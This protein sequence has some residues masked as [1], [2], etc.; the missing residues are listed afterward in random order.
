MRETASLNRGCM[1]LELRID[2]Q[3]LRERTRFFAQAFVWALVRVRGNAIT[4]RGTRSPALSPQVQY[5][6][7]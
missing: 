2:R 7:N 5:A 6:I 1:G 4:F 3:G